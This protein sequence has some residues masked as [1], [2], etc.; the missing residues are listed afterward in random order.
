MESFHQGAITVEFEVTNKC[1]ADCVM[2]PNSLMQRP[3]ERMEME[4]FKKIADEF[5]SEKLPLIKFVFAGLGEPTLDP[6]LP[7]KIRYLKNKLPSVP[8]QVTTNASLLNETRA[9]ALIESGLDLMIISF[10]GTS[11]E[12]YESV[13]VGMKFDRTLENVV[14]FLKLRKGAKPAVTLSCVRLEANARDFASI[15]KFWNEKGVT[16]ESFKTPI[17]FNRGGDQ[18]KDRYK[19]R[20]SLEKPSKKRHMLPCRMMA[21][22]L[23]IHP[24]GRVALCFVDYEE[25][26]ILGEFGKDSLRKIL[27]NKKQIFDSHLRGDFSKTPLCQNCSFMREQ[28]I[29]WWKDSYF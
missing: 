23:L 25:E 12:S 9:K 26:I 11:K 13:M 5:A 8:V 18:M 28:T 6:L 7:E 19:S 2:C 14:N 20:W 29:A 10:N 3:H 4:V 24:S 16:I 21:E 22:N 15:E 1:N 17:P 27:A